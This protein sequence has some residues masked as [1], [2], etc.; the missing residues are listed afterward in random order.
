[1]K[2]YIT[3]G[4]PYARVAR[5]VVLEKRLEG[6]VE[7]V[8]AQTRSADSPHYRIAAS[9]GFPIW[10]LTTGL[11]WKNPWS[12]AAIWITS[13]ANRRSMCRWTMRGGRRCA[14]ALWRP[15]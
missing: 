15:V 11:G 10:C 3:P 7:F 4:S 1:M 5:I 9:V 2:L 6:R 13:T 8:V 12:S 14:S